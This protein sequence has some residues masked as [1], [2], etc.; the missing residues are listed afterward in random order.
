MVHKMLGDEF[1]KQKEELRQR[2]LVLFPQEKVRP[3][4]S[5]EGFS[6]LLSLVGRNGQGVATSPF[7]QWVKKV[8]WNGG[9]KW[10]TYFYHNLSSR[11]KKQVYGIQ[12]IF[13]I[14]I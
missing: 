2:L 1:G 4:L 3:L 5:Q 9:N 14:F 10:V 11:Y 8:S 7:S 6:A 13:I 12:G